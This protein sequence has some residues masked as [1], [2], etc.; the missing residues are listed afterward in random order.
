MPTVRWLGAG[1]PPGGKGPPIAE[2]GI[3]ITGLPGL[4]ASKRA[5]LVAARR[6]QR[7]SGLTTHRA[8]HSVMVSEWPRF[9]GSQDPI[10]M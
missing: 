3:R 4:S 5:L 8:H 2:C 10:D 7:P 6:L 9:S 1:P